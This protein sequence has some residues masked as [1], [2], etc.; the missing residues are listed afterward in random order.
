MRRSTRSTAW[1]PR[2]P[3]RRPAGA[4]PPG[5]CRSGVRTGGAPLRTRRSSRG[6]APTRRAARAAATVAARSSRRAAASAPPIRQTGVESNASHPSGRVRSIDGSCGGRFPSPRI[7][8]VDRLLG[9]DHRDVRHGRVLGRLGTSGEQP[10]ALLGHAVSDE[11]PPTPHSRSRG[12]PR[13]SR[14]WCRA[15]RPPRAKPGRRRPRR[16]ERTEAEHGRDEGS[17]RDPS[18]E[19]LAEHRH[20]DHAESQTTSADSGHHDPEPALFG[21][22]TPQIGIERIGEVRSAAV[23]GTSP[24]RRA[25]GPVRSKPSRREGRPRPLPGPAD[26]RR[27][28]TPW[29][30]SL[31]A[32][33]A[34]RPGQADVAAA[35]AKLIAMDL[36]MTPEQ[37]LLREELREWLVANL[38]WAYG[39]EPPPR[40]SDLA[41]VVAFGREWQAK[42]AADRWVGV[43][44]PIELGGRGLGP[45]EHF[46]VTE[47]MARARAPE[48]V[49]RIGD[50]PG[51]TH[52]LRARHA[53]T[54]RTVAAS[55]PPGRRALVPA[56]QRTGCR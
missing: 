5:S 26:R 10:S 46:L 56:V 17:R 18:P 3:T 16:V 14:R 37:Q 35:C 54:T 53:R 50:Q 11:S 22:C 20:L 55:D 36:Q 34:A 39:T 45:T 1:P 2:R 23:L 25:R 43:T 38:P 48:L 28:R 24:A 41:E 52:P 7:C 49:G 27:D 42:L 32:A 40:P 29:R 9:G 19:L 13:A 12:P 8:G 47:E 30:R 33:R 4:S 21:H 15:R 31:R 51:G 6:R 44:W